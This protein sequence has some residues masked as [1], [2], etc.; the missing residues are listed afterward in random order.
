MSPRFFRNRWNVSSPS[1]NG[2]ETF[3]RLREI[4]GDIP[5]FLCTGF[6]QR[7]RLDRLMTAGIKGFLRKPIAP[8]ELVEHVR[9]VM[10]SLKYSQGGIDQSSLAG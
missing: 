6:I 7:D 10:A 8:D 3:Q 2:E 4:R 5:V 9:G 1:M